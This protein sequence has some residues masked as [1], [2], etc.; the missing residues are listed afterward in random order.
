MLFWKYSSSVFWKIISCTIINTIKNKQ[1][2]AGYG[3]EV[4]CEIGQTNN[5]NLFSAETQVGHFSYYWYNIW[6]SFSNFC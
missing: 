3:T 5:S 1:M 2:S 6:N 4:G